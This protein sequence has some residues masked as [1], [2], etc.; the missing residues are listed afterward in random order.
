MIELAERLDD[1]GAYV[2]YR[3]ERWLA[4]MDGEPRIVRVLHDV[5]RTD[6][7]ARIEQITR[8]W[9]GPIHPR[10]A[11]TH[12]TLWRGTRLWIV[13]DD[14]RGPPFAEAA[15]A[16]ADPD[17]RERWCVAQIIA[18]ADACAALRVRDPVISPQLDP[19]ALV[20][21]V[22]GH[23]RLRAPSAHLVM[24]RASTRSGPMPDLERMSTLSPEHASGRVP[25]PAASDV[26]ALA[27][28]L[29]IALT[30]RRPFEDENP[31]QMLVKILTAPVE[32]PALRT[33]GLDGVL[34]RAFAKDPA[35]RQRDAAA[36]A[37]EL[38]AVVP[39][40]VEYD[41][42]ISDRVVAW[43]SMLGG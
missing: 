24:G 5:D 2:E 18:I 23:V 3:Y 17:E 39:D 20:V 41:H 34:A 21:D 42:V 35:A 7:L 4:R 15:A 27:A 10:V 28:N 25:P 12:A 9:L 30:G 38:R 37:A 1:D 26:F 11:T 43:R 22:G 29:Y 13:V 40:H 19:R 14:D 32:L 16:L 8:L 33:P 31:M 6:E 36:L